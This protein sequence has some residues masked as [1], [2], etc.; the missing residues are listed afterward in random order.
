MS[1]KIHTS[2]SLSH[3]CAKATATD[4]LIAIGS[5]ES[6]LSIS[7]Q[8]GFQ[9]YHVDNLKQ[10]MVKIF[11]PQ[12]LAD[13]TNQG[14]RLLADSW[15]LNHWINHWANHRIFPSHPSSLSLLVLKALTCTIQTS[16]PRSTLLFCCSCGT[17]CVV[18]MVPFFCY[19][20]F[21]NL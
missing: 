16:L 10:S 13:T 15:L 4:V 12:K 6:I 17:H 19:L 5:G 20:H 18:S 9:W 2:S 14:S 8:P 7:L 11:T 1:F 3:Q 21:P